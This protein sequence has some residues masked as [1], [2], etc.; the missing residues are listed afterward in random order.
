[1]R[2]NSLGVVIVGGERLSNP[3]FSKGDVVLR[4]DLLGR[5][6]VSV[7]GVLSRGFLDLYGHGG[8]TA[9]NF[10]TAAVVGSDD[11]TD[12]GEHRVGL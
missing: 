2:G 5:H 3:Y 6:A 11:P 8:V 9:H 12:G 1:M 10:F 7:F 4:Y